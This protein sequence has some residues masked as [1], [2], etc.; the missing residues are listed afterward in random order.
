[1][2]SLGRIRFGAPPRWGARNLQLS[3]RCDSDPRVSKSRRKDAVFVDSRGG[4]GGG[5]LQSIE[6]EM[7]S[8][9]RQGQNF[10]L[11]NAQENFV[12]QFCK[13]LAGDL[14]A[15]C[16]SPGWEGQPRRCGDLGECG[17]GSRRASGQ[18]EKR[19]AI[20]PFHIQ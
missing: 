16:G 18:T 19:W 10:R 8:S 13:R 12:R 7:V 3:I 2:V 1:M 20:K 11:Q 15:V 9:L 5:T 4:V 14:R 17:F 6:T